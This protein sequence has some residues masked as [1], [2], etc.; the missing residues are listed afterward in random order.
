MILVERKKPH[1]LRREKTQS[2]PLTFTKYEGSAQT[3]LYAKELRFSTSMFD[4]HMPWGYNSLFAGRDELEMI[5]SILAG[6]GA[7]N[8]TNH[9]LMDLGALESF[10]SNGSESAGVRATL[11]RNWRRIKDTTQDFFRNFG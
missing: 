2:H 7:L 5:G 4:D 8:R 9:R 11:Q 3:D 1:V 6:V 10:V